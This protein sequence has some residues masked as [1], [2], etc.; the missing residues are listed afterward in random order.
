ME[1]TDKVKD[2]PTSVKYI[3][4]EIAVELA[5]ALRNVNA[6]KRGVPRGEAQEMAAYAAEQIRRA[7]E[8]CAK[9]GIS[10]AGYLQKADS[11]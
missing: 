9:C 5:G 3:F 10:A 2:L 7:G 11:K 1:L 6:I 4:D 8:M